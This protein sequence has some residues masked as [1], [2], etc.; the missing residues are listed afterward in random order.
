MMATD[1]EAIT[2]FLHAAIGRRTGTAARR[3]LFVAVRDLPYATDAASDAAAL[4]RLGRG[5]CLA[6]ADL[7][8]RGFRLL[9]HA[10]RRVRWCYHLPAQP[11]AVALLPSRDDVHT[12]VEVR[13]AGRW[14]LVDA[15]HDPPRARRLAGERL[16]RRASDTGSLRAAGAAIARRG[17]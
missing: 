3:A 17:G 8:A 5:N 4:V 14:V 9:G 6:K 11:P 15:T 2:R 7:L 13:L 1:D 12:A 10:A 16:G